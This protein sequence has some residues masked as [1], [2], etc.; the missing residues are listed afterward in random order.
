MLKQRIA[1]LIK[2]RFPRLL[3]IADEAY[4]AWVIYGPPTIVKRAIYAR[5]PHK[6]WEKRGETYFEEEEPLFVP[7]K[8]IGQR[9]RFLSAEIKKLKPKTILEV[10]CGYGAILKQ[11]KQDMKDTRIVGVDFSST[12]LDKARRWV[13]DDAIEMLMADATKRLPFPDNSFDMVFT[14]GVIMHIPPPHSSK[15]REEMIRVSRKYIAHNESDSRGF[16]LFG[17]DNED[18]Y[19]KRG[20]RILSRSTGNYK[21]DPEME[22]IVVKLNKKDKGKGK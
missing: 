5:N 11:M 3:P 20:H 1:R 19:K 2:T 13:N 6:Y 17:Q 4:T 9:A 7:T 12:Q 10:G 22:F 21:G 18:F 15:A 14:S 8:A 16:H